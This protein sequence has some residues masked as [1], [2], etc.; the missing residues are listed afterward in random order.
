MTYVLEFII[1][2]HFKMIPKMNYNFQKFFITVKRVK[3]LLNQAKI[4]PAKKK[5]LSLPLRGSF[6]IT[7]YYIHKGKE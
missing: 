4:V 2:E 5:D 6:V 1:Q 3:S 7:Y